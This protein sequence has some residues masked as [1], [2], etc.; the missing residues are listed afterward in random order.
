LGASGVPAADVEREVS[1]P[2]REAIHVRR[3]TQTETEQW[4]VE[5]E[6]L[7]GRLDQ[8]LAENRELSRRRDGLQAE[9]AAAESRITEKSK[10]LEDIEQVTGAI[11]PVVASLFEQLTASVGESLPF[12]P[13]ERRK[14]LTA[15][16]PLLGD[17]SVTINEKYRKVMEALLVEAEYGFSCDVYRQT[18]SIENEAT[19]VDIFRLGRLALFYL[20]LNKKQCGFYNVATKTWQPLAVRYL[21]QVK[22][23]V[24]IG[25][26]QLPVELLSLPVGRIA[27]EVHQ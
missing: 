26:K 27:G 14:R 9:I 19:L 1:L 5:K 7:A 18:I 10:E 12:L 6:K 25:L 22:K 21:P 16:Q 17:P 23:A 13:E 3:A 4:L 15:L 11:T 20:T 24:A 2:V 8:L